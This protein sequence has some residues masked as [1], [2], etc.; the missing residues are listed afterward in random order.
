MTR[1]LRALGLGAI[2]AGAA[3]AGLLV[4][5]VLA[6]GLPTLVGWRGYTVVSGSMEPAIATGDIVVNRQIE[7]TAARVGDVVTFA[8]AEG[9]GRLI[10]HRVS[11][12]AREA[13]LIR[14]VTKGDANTGVER[15]AVPADGRIGRVVYR[16]PRLGRALA[17]TRTPIGMIGLVGLPA[18]IV[19]GLEIRKLVRYVRP[20]GAHRVPR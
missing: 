15:W 20:G 4:G 5:L 17:W 1:I 7:P 12:V 19:G 6:A 14:F 2:A 10:T 3:V 11:S 13:E 16:L 18:L 8:D 9:S